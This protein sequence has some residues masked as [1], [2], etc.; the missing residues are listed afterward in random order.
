MYSEYYEGLVRKALDSRPFLKKHPSVSG[1]I[2]EILKMQNK[3]GDTLKDV[4]T[5]RQVSVIVRRLK[6]VS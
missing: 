2:D 5:S 6:L 4:P 1:I 3:D